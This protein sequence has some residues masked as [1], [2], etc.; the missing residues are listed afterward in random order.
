VKQANRC[1]SNRRYPNDSASGIHPGKVLFPDLKTRIENH[2]Y[3]SAFRVF[4]KNSIAL[5]EIAE[6]AGQPE[7]FFD[8]RPTQGIGKDMI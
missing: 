6:R 3:L 1:P 8:R 2:R 5:V 4:G 7:V